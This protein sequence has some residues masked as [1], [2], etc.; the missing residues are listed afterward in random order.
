MSL[1]RNLTAAI[2]TIPAALAEPVK[3]TLLNGDT[4]Q[5]DL[6]PEQSTDD[7]KVLIHPQLGRLEVSQHAIKPVEKSP[8]WKSTMSAGVNAGKKMETARSQPI[9]TAA[10]L[11][12][13]TATNSNLKPA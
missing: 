6:I 13:E 3:L 5:G 1:L 9:S 2:L 11:T 12:G 10:A 8:A 4:I 7:V